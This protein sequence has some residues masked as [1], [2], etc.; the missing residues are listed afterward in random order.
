M[1]AGGLLSTQQVAR[2]VVV[3]G[4]LTVGGTGKTP[5]VAWL[6]ERLKERRLSVGIVSR[7]Y[8]RVRATGREWSS[9]TR[10]G[11][12]SATS[13]LLLRQRT[14]CLT[15]VASDRVA[16]ARL[17]VERGVDVILADDGLQHL[18]LARDCE[19]VVVDGA[20]GFGNGWLLP[21]GPLREPVT[22]AAKADLIIVNGAPVAPVT[23]GVH[24]A[25]RQ[26]ARADDAHAGQRRPDGRAVGHAA[27]RELP[28]RE[29]ARG[30]RHRQPAALLFATC[31]RAGW[32]SSSIPFP[33]ITASPP[34]TL[35]FGDGAPVLMTE[36][37]AVKCR[38]FARRPAMVRARDR[39][40]Q[41]RACQRAARTRKL[42][43]PS[44]R[45]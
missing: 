22:Q 16:G 20:R 36:K 30:G 2:P 14:G 1:Y 11:V 4:N 33:I 12:R 23:G 40:L 27:A 10:A 29:G 18:R 26:I 37:D 5:L 8:G 7:G 15:V 34:P 32:T 31:A 6:A 28:R 41:R 38:A 25:R 19:L 21:A 44:A 13:R 3:V 45:G 24:R 43:S 39:A 35:T 17:L 42:G 9:P